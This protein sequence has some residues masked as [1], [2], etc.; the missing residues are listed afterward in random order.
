LRGQQY[1]IKVASDMENTVAIKCIFIKSFKRNP[2]LFDIF[3]FT[4]LCLSLLDHRVEGFLLISPKIIS[5]FFLNTVLVEVVP[6]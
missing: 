2:V 6:C 5:Y 3:Q 1:V 4:H